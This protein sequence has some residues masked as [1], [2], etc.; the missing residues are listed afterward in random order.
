MQ[1][2]CG[3]CHASHPMSCLLMLAAAHAHAWGSQMHPA[4]HHQGCSPSSIPNQRLP[5]L[6]PIAQQGCHHCG[7]MP[8]QASNHH[9]RRRCPARIRTLLTHSHACQGGGGCCCCCLAVLAGPVPASTPGH[10]LLLRILPRLCWAAKLREA[11]LS[12]AQELQLVPVV[13]MHR[14]LLWYLLDA[15]C[16]SSCIAGGMRLGCA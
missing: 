3:A 15:V 5:P 9:S 14:W 8:N 12:T 7:V 11:L 6:R 2:A 4:L 16:S 10:A 13:L 1:H